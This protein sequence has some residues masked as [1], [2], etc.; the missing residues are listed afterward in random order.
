M[1]GDRMSLHCETSDPMRSNFRHRLV[2]FFALLALFNLAAWTVLASLAAQVA[3]SVLSMGA[4][5]YVLGLKHG[6]DADHIAAIDNVTRKLRQ[7]GQRTI[8]TGL[9]F[10]L[11]HSTIVILL[12]LTLVAAA[13]LNIE[14]GTILGS[15]G[16]AVS[17]V[18]SAVFLTI[19]GIVNLRIFLQLRRISRA[20]ASSGRDA[21][22]PINEINELL[23]QRGLSGRVFGFLYRRIDASWKMFPLGFLFGLGFD[24]ATEI[25]VLGVS[26]K[27]AANGAMPAWMIMVF[28][29]MFTAGMTMVDA[30]DG[31]LM[32]E[33]YDWAL[34]DNTRKLSFNEIITGLSALMALA[35]G[36][37]EWFQLI[38]AHIRSMSKAWQAVE[39]L[40]FSEVGLAMTLLILTTW[41][42]AA[43]IY[44]RY[45]VRSSARG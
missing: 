33:M 7:D 36:T 12:S 23:N 27:A 11:G 1:T 29:L 22:F 3:V 41:L 8:M 38:G 14:R 20:Q 28:P 25:A 31:A 30:M 17:S 24:T 2:P 5:S 9:F 43:G 40:N 26:A 10:A 45:L 13:R 37:V 35:V 6:F 19:L 4:L 21:E 32:T 34:S 39:S 42:L 15:W 44:R 18:A 16:A